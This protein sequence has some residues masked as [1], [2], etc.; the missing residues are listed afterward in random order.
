MT[1]QEIDVVLFQVFKNDTDIIWNELFQTVTGICLILG[2]V[3]MRYIR[4]ISLEVKE[5]SW[6]FFQIF[7]GNCVN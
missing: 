7:G 5:M 1:L 3:H 4:E 6:N 2:C